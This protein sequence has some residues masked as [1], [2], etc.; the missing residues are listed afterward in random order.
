MKKIKSRK[1][2]QVTDLLIAHG[3]AG[4]GVYVM[5]TEYLSERKA[6]R[7]RED[8]GRIAYELHADAEMVRSILEDFNLFAVSAEGEFCN[9]SSAPTQKAAPTENQTVAPE[10]SQKHVPTLGE[11]KSDEA[12][13]IGAE[14]SDEA[15]RVGEERLAG[16]VTS[17]PS[18]PRTPQKPHP[19]Q[20]P[21]KKLPQKRLI[22]ITPTGKILRD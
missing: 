7:R 8:I 17:R 12:A 4:Y 11:E 22:K 19:G 15:V 3:P 14:N 21:Y 18:K 1:D 6:L 10:T 20:H 13:T 5:L 16:K 2:L 9:L